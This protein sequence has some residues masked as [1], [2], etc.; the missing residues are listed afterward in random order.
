MYVE[1]LIEDW[2][3]SDDEFAKRLGTWLED[4]LN[5]SDG[6]DIVDIKKQEVIGSTNNKK[7]AENICRFEN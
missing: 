7:T 5:D 3:K 1:D 6:D 4:I 2:K